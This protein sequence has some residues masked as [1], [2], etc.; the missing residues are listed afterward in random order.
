MSTELDLDR[1]PD[2]TWGQ[3]LRRARGKRSLE[4]TAALVSEAA[5]TSHTS[6][7]RLEYL[8]EAPTKGKLRTR[9]VLA[10]LVYGYDPADFSLSLEDLPR[11]VDVQRFAALL[12]SPATLRES[13]QSGVAQFSQRMPV[14]VGV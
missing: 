2:E 1:L 9:A 5:P 13:P 11:A 12:T 14:L 10:L 6:L 3:R 7:A 8:A 4:S